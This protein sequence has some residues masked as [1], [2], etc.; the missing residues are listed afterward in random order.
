MSLPFVIYVLIFTY[1]PIWGWVIAFLDYKPGGSILKSKFV[2]LRFFNEMFSSASFYLALRN[3]LVMSVL[4]LVLGTVI[5]VIFAILINELRNIAFKRTV[6]TI[7]YLPHFVSWVVVAGI[8][9]RLLAID[10]GTINDLLIKLNII[11][12]PIAFQMKGEWYWGI[13]TFANIWKE[14][15]WSA[16]IYIAVLVTINVEL[17]EAATADGAS[18][19]RRI[20]HISMPGIKNT[21][22]IMVVLQTGWLLGVGFDQALLMGNNAVMQYSDVLSTYVMR[23]GIQMGRFSF[24]TAA[25]IFQ[26]LIGLIMVVSANHLAKKVSNTQIF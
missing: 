5:S 11:S 6:Q 14:T 22:V 20:W 8:F 23:Y 12:D 1:I 26:S 7:S 25:G 18:R 24:A 19:F 17:Y 21:I 2:G 3:T 10:G 16:I 4:N 13:V 9:G 15:G